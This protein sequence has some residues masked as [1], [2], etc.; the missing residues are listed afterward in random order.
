MK[1]AA[2][3]DIHGNLPALEAVLDEIREAGVE[4]LVV[5]GDLLP[6]PMAREALDRLLH[7]DI[8][9]QFIHGNGEIDALAELQGNGATR[10]SEQFREVVHWSARQLTPDQVSLI[11][12]WPRTL[13][14][15][16]EEIGPV[17]F[18]HATPRDENEI[19]TRITPEEH[20]LPIFESLGESLVVCGHTHM[21]F[22]RMIG[23]TRVINAGSVGMAFGA[24]SA[25]WLLLGPAVEFRR[26]SY[27][28]MAA[29]K[30][31][32][33]TGYP[34]AGDFIEH[35]LLDPPTEE[36]MLE[37]FERATRREH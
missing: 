36:R 3:Y 5:G 14:I 7:L 22:D 23:V 11:A 6:G 17:L 15:E 25:H 8:P 37:V 20:L 29:S 10:V 1:V 21:Q 33:R 32:E 13:S 18:C 9:V 16:V 34:R 35:Y 31:I 19:F 2:I 26:T 24:S 4:L 28:V 30:R 12:S 27:D